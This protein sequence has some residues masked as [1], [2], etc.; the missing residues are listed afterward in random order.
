MLIQIQCR[1]MS[2]AVL[3]IQDSSKSSRMI[4]RAALC[5]FFFPFLNE[6][7]KSFFFFFHVDPLVYVDSYSKG[8][9]K[10]CEALANQKRIFPP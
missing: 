9:R 7:L 4:N 6:L 8:E 5:S 1:Q 3:N 2:H 10:G